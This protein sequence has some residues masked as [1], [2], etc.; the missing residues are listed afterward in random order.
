MKN[1]EKIL[2]WVLTIMIMFHDLLWQWVKLTTG[3]F[4]SLAGGIVVTSL[5][6]EIILLFIWLWLL[7]KIYKKAIHK[8]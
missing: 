3:P 8:D 6:G 2:F 4:I 1:W 7:I 5:I